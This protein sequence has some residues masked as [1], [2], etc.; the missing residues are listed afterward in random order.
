MYSPSKQ[1]LKDIDE[2]LRIYFSNKIA[3]Y[4]LKK[5]DFMTLFKIVMTLQKEDEENSNFE[6]S[7]EIDKQKKELIL[8]LETPTEVRDVYRGYHYR[9]FK[10]THTYRYNYKK[11]SHN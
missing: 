2:Q 3:N 11:P 10:L 7:V 8:V 4:L 6:F 1:E 5:I 9:N